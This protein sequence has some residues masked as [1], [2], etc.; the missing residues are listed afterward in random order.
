MC[1]YSIPSAYV[2]ISNFL[3]LDRMRV[4]KVSILK[5]NVANINGIY[6][7][8]C[9]PYFLQ[10]FIPSFFVKKISFEI[11]LMET[12]ALLQVKPTMF[13]V[14][15]VLISAFFLGPLKLLC[16]ATLPPFEETVQ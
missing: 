15:F 7:D 9:E 8:V 16:K 12:V 10:Y 6:S 4:F 13:F 1:T 14:S 11:P 2:H 3:L 5:S